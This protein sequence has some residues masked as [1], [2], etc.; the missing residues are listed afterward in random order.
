M[1]LPVYGN[2]ISLNQIATEFGGT[3]A[4]ALENYYAGGSYVGAGTVG[5]PTGGSSVAIPS[6]GVI[7]LASFYGASYTPP[8]FTLGSTTGPSSYFFTA[9]VYGNSTFV[10]LSYFGSTYYIIYS[11]NGTTWSSPVTVTATATLNALAASSSYFV[12]VGNNASNYG[13]VSYASASTPSSWTSP[14]VMGSGGTASQMQS[15]CYLSTSQKF[16]SVG[17]GSGLVSAISAANNPAAWST[18]SALSSTYSYSYSSLA[19]DGTNAICIT[20]YTSGATTYLVYL[21]YNGGTNS[22]SGPFSFPS[23]LTGGIQ[24]V[25]AIAYGNGTW[26]VMVQA[27][28]GNNTYITT[29]TNGTTWTTPVLNTTFSASY[30]TFG[31]GLFLMQ[32][33]THTGN[34]P[35]TSWSNDNGVTWTTPVTYSG[36]DTMTG[37]AY[38][39]ISTTNYYVMFARSGNSPSFYTYPYHAP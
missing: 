9:P 7:S 21:I 31:N 38:G 1:T 20:P 13:A 22:W 2:S 3:G 4:L 37:A 14:A 6:S 27:A 10:A 11:T 18:P 12:A 23:P 25:G 35:C 8:T 33:G 34:T 24:G 19:T 5:Y 17:L 32:G 29:S 16:L 28:T 26:V 36:P 15:V 39:T 30:L